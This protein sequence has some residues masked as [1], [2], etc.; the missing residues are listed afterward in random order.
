MYRHCWGTWIHPVAAVCVVVGWGAAATRA[1]AHLAADDAL[2][3]PVGRVWYGPQCRRAP[4]IKG[5]NTAADG[6]THGTSAAR[7]GLA[8]A[9]RASAPREPGV[10]CTCWP[11]PPT[12]PVGFYQRADVP[13]EPGVWLYMSANPS[14]STGR[15]LDTTTGRAH[16]DIGSLNFVLGES[17]GMMGHA[18]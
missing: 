18:Y 12:L 11:T 9:W 7:D 10:G 5:R 1:K 8:G 6:L 2:F 4:A 16:T 14:H 3:D 17:A 15:I 13:W